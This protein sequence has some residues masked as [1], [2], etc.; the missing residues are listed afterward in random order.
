MVY[1]LFA[2]VWIVISTSA[3]AQTP[4]LDP[5]Q[6]KVPESLSAI[7]KTKYPGY[8]YPVVADYDKEDVEQHRK[9]FGGDPCLGVTSADV[10]G[11][12]YPDFAFFL[13]DRAGST[14]LVAARSEMGKTWIV[15]KLDSFPKGE[16]GRSYV[17]PLEAG[18]YQDLYDSDRGPSDYSPEPGRVRR[19]HSSRPGFIAGTIESSGIAFFYTGKHWVHLWLSD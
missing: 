6:A 12:G 8:R 5:C 16:L 17:E 2:L 10:D 19:Y 15:T 1:R 3:L 13:T 9:N 4:T 14:L 7:V 18:S 11:D